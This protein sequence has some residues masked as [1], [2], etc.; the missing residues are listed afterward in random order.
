M[1]FVLFVLFNEV[2]FMGQ[3]NYFETWCI[4]YFSK[5]N[6]IA[7]IQLVGFSLD[8]KTSKH[9]KKTVIIMSP[10]SFCYKIYK[11]S[12]WF[13]HQNFIHQ[14]NPIQN[15]INKKQSNKIKNTHTNPIDPCKTQQ[16]QSQSRFTTQHQQKK[17]TGVTNF[18]WADFPPKRVHPS[19]QLK[20]Y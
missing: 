1:Q 11:R 14:K 8:I 13:S 16:V 18:P 12:D 19:Q 9:L 4:Y 10:Q 5:Q 3:S 6:F 2:S 17:I 20:R 15:Y 7:H